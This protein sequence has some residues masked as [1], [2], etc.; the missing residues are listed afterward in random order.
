MWSLVLRRSPRPLLRPLQQDQV[1]Q[2]PRASLWGE[3]G[4]DTEEEKAARKRKAEESRLI[5]WTEPGKNL[6]EKA[7]YTYAP[8]RILDEASTLGQSPGPWITWNRPSVYQWLRKPRLASTDPA[9]FKDQQ[10]ASRYQ[11]LVRAQIFLRERVQALG[12]DLAAAQFLLFRNC[13][14]RFKGHDHWTELDEKRTARL[15]SVYQPGWYVEAVDAAESE[16]VYEGFQNLRNLV[17]LKYLDLS[18]SPHIDSWCLDRITGE[19]KDS[20]E[21][22]DLSGCP[23]VDWS[24]LECLWRLKRLK[25]LVLYDMEHVKDI[26]LLC[27][28]LLE[29]FPNLDIRGVDYID[30][31]LLE[32]TE[33]EH[34]LKELDELQALPMP[35]SERRML[36]EAARDNAEKEGDKKKPVKGDKTK[37]SCVD[38]AGKVP[39]TEQEKS[40]VIEEVSRKRTKS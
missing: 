31:K 16:L 6:Q 18:Y 24:G 1:Q 3:W 5:K 29:V 19:Y 38:D 9:Y 8:Q 7:P 39:S 15:P 26:Q 27:I 20:L 22:L 32:G 23:G 30:A 28:M 17:F 2:V 4:H 13:R 21:Y 33:H 10:L 37:Q 40:H 11:A 35:E 25:T 12:P 14:V 34:L 36:R